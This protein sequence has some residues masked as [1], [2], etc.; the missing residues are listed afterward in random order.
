MRY[1]DEP[2]FFIFTKAV[3]LSPMGRGN[4]PDT[5]GGRE[6]VKTSTDKRF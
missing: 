4:A 2:T 5:V 6:R 3:S 1:V